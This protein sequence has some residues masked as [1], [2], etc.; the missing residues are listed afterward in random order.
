MVT[1]KSFPVPTQLQQLP[2]PS[3]WPHLQGPLAYAAYAPQ[4]HTPVS[5]N[6]PPT[7]TSHTVQSVRFARP[8]IS[9]KLLKTDG[10]LQNYL[11]IVYVRYLAIQQV[12]VYIL[13]PVYAASLTA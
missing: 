12:C 13:V 10:I 8:N 9:Y 1:N 4:P 11:W 2:D 7:S 6:N 3:I 5:S